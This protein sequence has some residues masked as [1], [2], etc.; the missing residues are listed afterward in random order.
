MKKIFFTLLCSLLLTLNAAA[1]ESYTIRSAGQGRDGNYLVEVVVS[2]KKKPGTDAE[3]LALRYAVHGVL[4]RGI[5]ARDG[6]GAQNALISDPAIEQTKAQFFNAC[7]NEGTYK[8]FASIS[9]RS[10]SVMANKQTKMH[11]TSAIV[12][13][14]KEALRHYLEENGVVQGFSNLW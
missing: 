1:Q 6:Y 3:N 2:T 5:S 7:W 12:T 4:F 13:I 8:N 11:D 14:N 10:L 9:G